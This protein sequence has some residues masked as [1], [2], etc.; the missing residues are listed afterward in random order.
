MTKE[1]M[2][3]DFEPLDMETRILVAMPD[4]S[5]RYTEHAYYTNIDGEGFLVIKPSA[6]DTSGEPK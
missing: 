5:F 3:F 2:L 4:G 1:D 6:R